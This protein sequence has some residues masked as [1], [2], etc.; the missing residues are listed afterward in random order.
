MPAYRFGNMWSEYATANLFLITTNSTI[1][2]KGQLVMGRGIAKEAADRYP[3]LPLQAGQIIQK[4]CGNLGIYGLYI[5]KHWP[6]TKLG[7]FQVKRNYKDKAELDLI[8]RSINM[9]DF[10]LIGRDRLQVHL[11]FPG[12][13][14]AY[15]EVYPIVNVLGDNVVIWTI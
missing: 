3:K 5:S 11:N 15:E 2:T 9:L 13:G 4:Y 12:G 7:L 14:L 10:W 6:K 1:N 8:Q